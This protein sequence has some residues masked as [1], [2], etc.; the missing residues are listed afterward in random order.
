MMKPQVV[1][2]NTLM[3][4]YMMWSSLAWK[5][6]E[7]AMDAAQ[8]IGHRSNRMALAGGQPSAADQRE[9]ALM[10]SEKTEAMTESVK[11]VGAGM[12]AV[13]G[14]M[15]AMAF[16]QMMSA[17]T[18]M[19]SLAFSTTPAQ[20]HERH[21]RLMRDMM[22]SAVQSAT[23]M[24]SANADLAKRALAPVQARVRSNVKRLSKG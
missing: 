16:Q 8:V 5:T 11:A 14:Q 12:F 7:M 4:P 3:G 21:G 17:S 1:P 23:K 10:T 24:S 2:W 18:A 13:G 6:G 15:A 20:V 22:N 9:F 19:M